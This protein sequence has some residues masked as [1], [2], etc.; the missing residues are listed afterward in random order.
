M[1]EVD[2]LELWNELVTRNTLPDT[3]RLVKR[4]KSHGKK[5]MERPD[6]LLDF[7]IQFSNADDD[8]IDIGP[9]NGRW[10]IPLAKVA[11]KVTAIEPNPAMFDMIKENIDKAGIGNVEILQQKWEDATPPMH[12]VTICAHGIYNSP[13]LEAFVRK[14]EHFS[15]KKC[16]LA[17][18]LPPAEG[19]MAELSLKIYDCRHDSPDAIVAYNALYSIGIYT[20]VLI[21]NNITNWVDIK[22]EDAFKRAKRHLNLD[23]S[24]TTHDKLIYTVLNSR[25]V[26]S[27]GIYTWPDGMR[28]ALLWWIPRHKNRNISDFPEPPVGL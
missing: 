16:Y 4:Y 15:R 27:D 8:L 19:I 25:L 5:Q 14:M 21:E 6:P 3:Q 20:N 7:I 9:G 23:V 13:D 28:S 22:V 10:T 11:N 1:K 24:D 26:P 18:R 2:W 17:L 12:D